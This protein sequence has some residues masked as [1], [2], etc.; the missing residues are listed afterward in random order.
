VTATLAQKL[1]KSVRI[2]G[3]F[4]SIFDEAAHIHLMMLNGT[5]GAKRHTMTAQIA[6]VGIG[7][8]RNLALLLCKAPLAARDTQTTACAF[9]M[10]NGN[11]AHILLH[12]EIFDAS[13]W[14][15]RQRRFVRTHPKS[16]SSP[17]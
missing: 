4:T 2:D 9:L 5:G 14:E 1:N 15:K 11:P 10:I 7:C 3:S 6:V 16:L 13:C 8:G 12:F 17:P